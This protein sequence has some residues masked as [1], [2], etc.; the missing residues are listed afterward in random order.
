[1]RISMYM[2]RGLRAFRHPIKAIKFISPRVLSFISLETIRFWYYYRKCRKPKVWYGVPDNE[3]RIMHEIEK[4]LIEN[5]F[6]IQDYKVSAEDVRDFSH[7]AKQSRLCC[8]TL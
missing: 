4:Q 5:G 8:P 2:E 3:P 7:K 1:M 6:K